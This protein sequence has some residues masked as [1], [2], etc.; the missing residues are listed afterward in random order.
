MVTARVTLRDVRDEGGTRHLEA[1]LTAEGDFVFS[2]QDLGPG[3]ESVF[4]SREYEWIWTIRRAQVAAFAR[5]L[6]ATEATLLATIA[7]RFADPRCAEI[8]PFLESHA[9]PFERWSRI[10]D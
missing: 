9:I 7:A 1:C 2:G 8:E 4:G 3:V 5:A 10:G 6:G